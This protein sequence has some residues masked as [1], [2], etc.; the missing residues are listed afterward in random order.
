MT[1]SV[2]DLNITKNGNALVLGYDRQISCY[3]L[4]AELL[5]QATGVSSSAM[6][7]DRDILIL[8]CDKQLSFR[9]PDTGTEAMADVEIQIPQEDEIPVLSLSRSVMTYSNR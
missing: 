4:N 8:L 7:Q 3:D 6:T 9:N 5:W 1:D 2:K